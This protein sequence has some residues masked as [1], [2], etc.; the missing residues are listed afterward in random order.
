MKTELIDISPTQKQLVL[1]VPSSVV[2]EEIARVARRYTRTV[3]IPGFRPGKAPERVV[4]RRYREQILSDAVQDL[5]PR[6]LDEVLRERALDPIAEPDIR[7]VRIEEGQPLTFTAAFEVLPPVDPIDYDTITLRRTPIE[8]PDEA[9]DRAI[10]RLRE[11]HARIE[12]VEGR[13]AARGDLLTADVVRRIRRRPGGEADGGEETLADATIEIGAPANPPGFDA[14][15]LG[16][17]PGETRTFE[18]TFPD[19]YGVET[20]AGA[21]VEYAVTVK[22]IKQRVLPAVDD[23]FARDLEFDSI[24]ALRARVA[25]DLRRDAERAQ[26][27]ELRSDLLRQ[28]AARV[29]FD[30]PETLVKR[31]MDRRL[32]TLAEDLIDHGIDP[33]QVNLDWQDLAE[34]QRE[35]SVS[36]VKATIVLDDVARREGIEVTPEELDAELARFARRA[37]RRVEEVRARLEAEGGLDRLVTGLRRDKTVE[38]LLSR[39]TILEA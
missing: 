32:R 33:R 2:E 7:D 35:G 39:V 11:R 27:Q 4:R 10:E 26:A 19:T 16:M 23:E 9:V 25:A 18:V 12:P 8:V 13:P 14:E 17:E 29:S 3:R 5:I 38:F 31:E 1:E 34:R 21:T 37:G 22:A 15:V 6:T 28:L 20:L 36:A 24:E 30:V